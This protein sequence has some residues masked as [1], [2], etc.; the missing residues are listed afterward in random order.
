MLDDPALR[1][2]LVEVPHRQESPS[3]SISRPSLPHA[4]ASSDTA[5]LTA[6]PEYPRIVLHSSSP[7]AN[8]SSKIALAT[9]V[10]IPHAGKPNVPGQARGEYRPRLVQDDSASLHSAGESDFSSMGSALGEGP[11]RDH[12]V[13]SRPRSTIS[14]YGP[15]SH[16]RPATRSQSSLDAFYPSSSPFSQLGSNQ[17]RIAHIHP[18]QNPTEP[19][20]YFFT[21][22]NLVSEDVSYRAISHIWGEPGDCTAH[23]FQNNHRYSLKVR[24]SLE[25][26]LR[27]IR[28]ESTEIS[29]WVDMLCID[30]ADRE[31]W[32]EQVFLMPLIFKQ[33][34]GVIVWL[35]VGDDDSRTAMG[36]IPQLVNLKKF[37]NLVKSDSTPNQWQALVHLMQNK[38]F[39]RR[40]TFLE[41]ILAQQVVIY[42]GTET[43]LWEDFCDAI[44]LLGSRFEKIQHLCMRYAV[45]NR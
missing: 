16:R 15:R 9:T 35:G 17:I 26:V 23:C 13:P 14:E 1:G 20:S 8:P 31:E 12:H 6:E 30:Q 2:D 40:W 5:L 32:D 18:S 24:P 27:R 22:H 38:Y 28:D 34:D 21:I 25:T 19:I 4:R 10:T 33:A 36:F 3:T 41:V 37:D 42:C 45:A 44:L 43:V 11:E 39:S 29:V 7:Y